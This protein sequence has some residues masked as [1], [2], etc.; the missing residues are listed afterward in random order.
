MEGEKQRI[1]NY[2][3]FGLSAVIFVSTIF[4]VVGSFSSLW[5]IL[6][7]CLM[8]VGLILYFGIKRSFGKLIFV[9]VTYAL[10]IASLMLN[11]FLY[12]D[13]SLDDN[14]HLIECRVDAIYATYDN[15]TSIIAS[16][17]KVS[18]NK[19][20]GR[21]LVT[22][23]GD[24]SIEIGDEITFE[25]KVKGYSIFDV[26]LNKSS[27]Y[28]N[29]VKYY[30]SA[31]EA[32]ITKGNLTPSEK[33]KLKTK[34]NLIS[35]MGERVGGLAYA[36]LYGDRAMIES[37]IYDSFRQSGTAHL[38]AISGLHISLII[39]IVYFLVSKIKTKNVVKFLI[40][41]AFLFVYDYLCEFAVSVV[42]A[43]IMGLTLIACKLFGK[44]YDSLS[45]LG[46][47]LCIILLFS[48]L[49]LYDVGLLL[50]YTAVLA[51]ILFSRTLDKVKFPNNIIRKIITTM[52][53]T[54][55][56]TLFTYPIT[57]S[58]FRTLPIYSVITNL[59][60]IPL[61]TLG[62]GL[63]FVT[64][65]FAFVGLKF[66]LYLPKI[67]FSIIIAI[68]DFVANLP[69]ATLKVGG[70]SIGVCLLIYVGLF[71]ISRFVMLKNKTKVLSCFVIFAICV[72]ILVG[73]YCYSLT[74][75]G[76]YAD[77]NYCSAIVESG[78]KRY[79]VNPKL[80]KSYIYNLRTSLNNKDIHDID[81][82]IFSPN[83]NQEVKMLQNFL[84]YFDAKVLVSS[85]SPMLA[86]LNSSGVKYSFY[87]DGIS[88]GG[89]VQV[90]VDSAGDV[91]FTKIVVNGTS[92]AFGAG[93]VKN[94]DF[95][96]LG[97]E[98]D[99]LET[100]KDISSPNIKHIL[101]DEMYINCR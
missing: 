80:S 43:S 85:N 62:F 38:L 39:S 36:L 48:P 64:N 67:I 32:H 31:S 13:K 42:R 3:S 4:F 18:G 15:S 37:D 9:V 29:N 96:L 74:K 83:S 51:I 97:Y 56:V 30:S 49:S 98:I 2:R 5:Y 75:C 58:Y 40:M 93:K 60:V 76:V 59:V 71:V 91:K 24:T 1:I 23:Y 99:Y 89:N 63:L 90:S 28:K 77:N 20:L 44:R 19:K 46:L 87:D 35:V 92:F 79:L 33:L 22:L 73:N 52:F 94:E 55:V 81:V 66:L 100:N 61:F 41:F 12:E 25:A 6:P 17:I 27:L 78:G 57:A 84:E 34:S 69:Y 45:S 70:I 11:I 68:V 53:I 72:S 7:L 10:I 86:N 54:T 101:N 26:A 47:S 82:I 8:F 65:I 21:M 95:D 14:K 50:S 16:G 88:L